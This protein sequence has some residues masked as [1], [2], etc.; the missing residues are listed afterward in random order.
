MIF[1]SSTIHQKK[2]WRYVK[3]QQLFPE[4]AECHILGT[5]LS[6]YHRPSIS[7]PFAGLPHPLPVLRIH[8]KGNNDSDRVGVG[9][10]DGHWYIAKKA[11][12]DRRFG[13]QE[14]GINLDKQCILLSQLQSI[15]CFSFLHWRRAICKAKNKRTRRLRISSRIRITSMI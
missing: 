6:P 14:W 5:L 8:L 1:D 13:L 12:L 2:S 3:R 7:T 15:Q 11:R 9:W 10:R 4:L